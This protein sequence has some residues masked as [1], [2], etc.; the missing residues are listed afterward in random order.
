MK[1]V[2]DITLRDFQ[3]LHILTGWKYLKDSIVQQSLDNSMFKISVIEDGQCIGIARVVGD[4]I[5]HGLLS[6]VII[7]PD[8]Q[9]KGYG[10]AM[11]KALLE[12]I[13]EFVN[14]NGD[15][16]LVELLP[17]AGNE[18]FYVKCGLKYNPA[19]MA[20]CYKW[21]KNQNRYCQNSKKYYMNLNPEPFASIKAGTKT[22]EMRLLDEKRQS[23]KEGD[24]IIFVNREDIN[25]VVMT[26]II[27]LHKFASFEELY[28][29]FDKKVLGYK[30][31]ET[32]KPS[33]MSKY[34][35]SEDIKKYGVL[36]IE[37]ELMD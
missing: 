22:I 26:K 18:G 13:Q 8:Y 6:D 31:F 2:Y 34:Y 36:G 3:R 7:C 30:E 29:N 5:C 19:Q 16:F 21:F 27:K 24:C 12:K 23:L 4:G 25:Q 9:R 1:F 32:A 17:T 35:S 37:I 11:I 10:T 28:R 33:D 15:E 14:N 20:G